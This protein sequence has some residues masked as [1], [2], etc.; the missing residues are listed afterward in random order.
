[1][2]DVEEGGAYLQ[3]GSSFLDVPLSPSTTGQTRTSRL[4]F[5]D[6][7]HKSPEPPGLEAKLVEYRKALGL[8]ILRL[9]KRRKPLAQVLQVTT[10]AVNFDDYGTDEVTELALNLRDLLH[11]SALQG[12]NAGLRS[13]RFAKSLESP[14]RNYPSS[15]ASRSPGSVSPISPSFGPMYASNLNAEE[16]AFKRDLT[17]ILNIVGDLI[18]NDC[19]YAMKHS[20]PSRPPNSLQSIVLDIVILLVQQDI[21]DA[22]WLYEVGTALLPAFTVFADGPM[23]ERVVS[24]Y[25]DWILPPLCSKLRS[26]TLDSDISSFQ[27]EHPIAMVPAETTLNVPNHP[28]DDRFASVNAPRIRVEGPEE[29]QQ[30]PRPAML[31]INVN[32]PEKPLPKLSRRVSTVS[33]SHSGNLAMEDYYAYSLFTPLFLLLLGRGDTTSKASQNDNHWPTHGDLMKSRNSQASLRAIEY[34]MQQKTDA[35]LNLLDVIANTPSESRQ[36]AIEILFRYYGNCVGHLSISAPLHLKHDSSQGALEHVWFAHIFEPDTGQGIGTAKCVNCL[37]RIESYGLRC[38]GCRS[39]VHLRC[40]YRPNAEAKLLFLTTSQGTRKLLFPQFCEG[41]IST[42]SRILVAGHDFRLTNLF[43]LQLCMCCKEPLWGVCYQGYCCSQCTRFVHQSCLTDHAKDLHLCYADEY[44]E[45]EILIEATSLEASFE[46]FW[47]PLYPRQGANFCYEEISTLQT[48]LELQRHLYKEGVTASCI[49]VGS[50]NDE[51]DSG[52]RIYTIKALEDGLTQCIGALESIKPPS[53]QYLSEFRPHA[54]S[55]KYIYTDDAYL[56]HI[57]AMLKSLRTSM[58]DPFR[59]AYTSQ[60]QLTV[61]NSSFLDSPGGLDSPTYFEPQEQL[62]ASEMKAWLQKELG[63]MNDKL[64]QILLQQFLNVGLMQIADEIGS[65]VLSSSTR[66]DEAKAFM[67]AIPT[68]LDFSPSVDSLIDAIEACLADINLSV[69]E[70]G[71]L[72]LTRRCWPDAFISQYTCERLLYG[73][74]QWIINEDEKLLKIHTRYTMQNLTPPGV[75][76]ARLQSVNVGLK[77]RRNRASALLESNSGGGVY[78]ETRRSLKDQYLHGWLYGLHHLE[79]QCYA[80]MIFEVITR[81]VDD[82]SEDGAVGWSGRSSNLDVPILKYDE[83]LGCLLQIHSQGLLFDSFPFLL[84]RWM[85]EV[86]ANIEQL[87][88]RKNSLTQLKNLQKLFVMDNRLAKRSIDNVEIRTTVFLTFW[89]L[90]QQ[91]TG[92][93]NRSEVR[94]YI[95]PDC[96]PS[97]WQS[98]NPEFSRT[99]DIRLDLMMLLLRAD[100]SSLHNSIIDLFYHPEWQQRFIALDYVYTIFTNIDNSFQNKWLDRLSYLGLMWDFFVASL[101]DSEEYVRTKV[102]ALLHAMQSSHISAGLRCWEAYF[103]V[104]SAKQREVTAKNML[105]LQAKFPSWPILDWN[106]LMDTLELEEDDE[107]E[108]KIVLDVV[109]ERPADSSTQIGS[110]HTGSTIKRQ[111][112]LSNLKVLLLTLAL[113][114]IAANV[115]LS[116]SKKGRFGRC[117]LRLMGFSDAI[118]GDDGLIGERELRIGTLQYNPEGSTQTSTFLAAGRCLKK[119]FDA[120]YFPTTTAS[121]VGTKQHATCP[122]ATPFWY[123]VVF[124][125]WAADFDHAGTGHVVVKAWLEV[126]HIIVYKH[127]IED[128]S[129]HNI[130]AAGLQRIRDLLLRNISEENKR[131]IIE[132]F[133]TLLERSY[134]LAARL[135][136]QQIIVVSRLMTSLKGQTN[137]KLFVACAHFLNAALIKF[138]SAGLFVLL[139][140][141]YTLGDDNQYLDLCH[142]LQTTTLT[143][144]ELPS[145]SNAP[146]VSLQEQPILDV[147]DKLLIQQMSRLQFSTVLQNMNLYMTKVYSHPYSSRVLT[148]FSAFIPKL[149]RHTT[150]WPRGEWDV[151]TILD[152]AACFLFHHPQEEKMLVPPTRTFLR[153]AI[154]T[155]NVKPQ[156]LARLLLARATLLTT[157][158]SSTDEAFTDIILEEIKIALRGRSRVTQGTFLS[159]LQVVLWDR[160]PTYLDID[161]ALKHELALLNLPQGSV[162]PSLFNETLTTL[163]GDLI[164]FMQTPSI[165]RIYNGQD[166]QLHLTIVQVATS[167]T[168]QY[169][170]F[171][172]SI[173]SEQQRVDPQSTLRLWT[174]FISGLA[175]FETTPLTAKIFEYESTLGTFVSSVINDVVIDAV[176]TSI[177]G[178]PFTTLP[179]ASEKTL[180]NAFTLL[181]AISIVFV[182]VSEM[183]ASPSLNIS[184]KPILRQPNRKFGL[185]LVDAERNIWQAVWPALRKGLLSGVGA[186]SEGILS[187]CITRGLLRQ[188]QMLRAIE[189]EIVHHYVYEWQTTL[190]AAGATSEQVA[191]VYP[192]SDSFIPQQTWTVEHMRDW[193]REQLKL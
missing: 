182:S 107:R 114:M 179:I 26:E 161:A 124:K 175:L 89:M 16:S 165:T 35:Y 153:Y 163:F 95:A 148:E 173:I 40:Y 110:M 128:R 50:T 96:L 162:R 137:N 112:K 14:S 72:L 191:S 126:V 30:R 186:P 51:E 155:G 184:S 172:Y 7:F 24:V 2:A 122:G 190:Q 123:A 178:D 174:W 144:P 111:H 92:I 49:Q 105:Q 91:A 183:T 87:T 42:N 65:N 167:L 48:L 28:Q 97:L 53:S 31:K 138:A 76:I 188:V 157:G 93:T 15:P 116:R 75:R 102:D 129:Q 170:D 44:H 78:V 168:R 60:N 59:D 10:T 25:V 125:F 131:L 64:C 187:Q 13:D 6:G 150:E 147:M 74:L 9:N 46:R 127:N 63:F 12:W 118:Y 5:G 101:T 21:E 80:D 103:L 67:F 160:N 32:A 193:L 71:F 108:R 98:M 181:S 1:M 68:A 77:A 141:K 88:A 169:R 83:V 33:H 109:D 47:T 37:Q 136:E 119:I 152:I 132:I 23:F 164:W 104:C 73:V 8:L 11:I 18:Q 70:T 117:F 145:T 130:I 177:A 151:N 139:F 158:D 20:R 85:D 61:S 82:K 113:E 41:A 66:I 90:T 55:F 192:S 45:H 115:E 99:I 176:Q 39:S 159:L 29:T 140:K 34:L 22:A 142:V 4:K 58:D 17:K 156:T 81:I 56:S 27:S 43:T 57:L 38:Y 84:T 185:T 135:L 143:V 36:H 134:D 69:N 171:F 3:A 62:T 79:S 180:Q 146:A 100:V 120:F 154:A 189:S 121:D 149:Q 94:A 133:T 86:S 19:R 106:T 166:F 54:A 52:H